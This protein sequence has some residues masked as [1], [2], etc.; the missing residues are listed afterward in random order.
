MQADGGVPSPERPT[1][2][3]GA[4][5]LGPRERPDQVHS[6][7]AAGTDHDQAPVREHKRP[8]TQRAAAARIAPGHRAS[9]A[10]ASA[11]LRPAVADRGHQAKPGYGDD[12]KRQEDQ[13]ARTKAEQSE[14]EHDPGPNRAVGENQAQRQ[15]PGDANL[16]GSERSL[17]LL[18]HGSEAVRVLAPG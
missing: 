18:E 2:G 12:H 3:R 11:T 13:D 8:H 5:E 7:A 9:G 14:A 1:G 6:T 15:G 17:A 4:C 16:D 10:A